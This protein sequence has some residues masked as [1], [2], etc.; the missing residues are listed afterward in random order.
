MNL[1]EYGWN[2]W[3]ASAFQQYQHD[4]FSAGRITLHTKQRYRVM[5]AVGEMPGIVTGRLLY[6][7]HTPDALPVVGDWVV[8]RLTDD[9]QAVIHAVLPRQSR[10]AR[11]DPA[12]GEQ[13]VAAN[14]DVAF[15]VTG[16]DG[17]Y[18][19]RRIERY[20][21][22][23]HQCG[24]TPV[25]VLTKADACHCVERRTA[26]VQAIVDDVQVLAVSALQ[27]IG[28]ELLASHL[29]PGRTVVLLGSSGAGKSTL[30]NALA[31]EAVQAVAEVRDGDSKGRHTTTRRQLFRVPGGALVLDT[32]GMREL[33]PWDA[34]DGLSATFAEIESLA[35]ACRFPDCRHGHEPGCA[36]LAAV[37]AGALDPAR[38]ANYQRLQREQQFQE[39]RASATLA[40]LERQRWKQI[41]KEQKR[42]Q[43]P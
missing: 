25:V 15:L 5:T 40:Q 43:K 7:A 34:D 41:R 32:P 14:V 1:P 11:R 4:G 12:G 38:F 29:L 21:T 16:L 13:S 30:L 3:H 24:V 23:T 28:L 39:Q 27:G 26:E 31:G 18:N 17:D 8:A 19:T 42:L 22:M 9:P 37:N 20:L 10:F 35:A 33:E 6:E 36:V 2:D